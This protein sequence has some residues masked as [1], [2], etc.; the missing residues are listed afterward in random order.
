MAGATRSKAAAIRTFPL[1]PN[2]FAPLKASARALLRYGL[3]P[4]PGDPRLARHWETALR[5]PL[6]FVE[7]RFRRSN[8]KFERLPVPIE[9]AVPADPV[10]LNYMGGA[11]TT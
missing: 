8:E 10:R 3:P 2:G 11:T 7:P 9:P 6:T 1:P 5:R 4:R